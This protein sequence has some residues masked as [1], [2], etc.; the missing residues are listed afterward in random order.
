M[1]LAEKSA[2]EAL[3]TWAKN[4]KMALL[5]S[6]GLY[7]QMRNKYRMDAYNQYGIK[8]APA[9]AQQGAPQNDPLGILGKG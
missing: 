5:Q 6:P 1:Q 7:D 3:D 4:N 2:Q 9:L 8:M